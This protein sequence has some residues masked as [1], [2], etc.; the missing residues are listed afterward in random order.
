MTAGHNVTED[1]ESRS[2]HQYAVVVQD[3]AT[4]WLQSYPCKTNSPQGTGKSSRKFLE[5]SEKP[6]VMNTDNSVEFDRA[7][8]ELSWNHCKSTPHRSETNGIAERA[9]RRIKEGTFASGVAI[10]LGRKMVGGFHGMLLLSAERTRLFFVKGRHHLKGD[11]V[12]PETIFW[13]IA[14]NCVCRSSVPKGESF[15]I[16]LRFF[17]VVRRTN[18]FLDVL[19][20]SRIDDS[21]N[22]D[23]QLLWTSFTQ[24][25]KNISRRIHVVRREADKNSSNIKA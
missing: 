3:L 2:N 23:G 12:K 20:E 5:P 1:C 18:T 22:V 9:V 6:N 4:Q 10:R 11:V 13:T 25:T 7:C 17:D 14:A 21:W 8:A 24:F 16:P 15:P 19:L